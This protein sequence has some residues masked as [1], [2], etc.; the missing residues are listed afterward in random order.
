[1]TVV[2]EP[3]IVFETVPRILDGVGVSVIITLYNYDSYITDALDS[4]YSQSYQNIELI[5]VDDASKDKS[6]DVARKWLEENG[7]RFSQARLLS[8]I[9]N[10]GLAQARNTAFAHARNEFIFVLDADNEIYPDAIVKLL[11]VCTSARAEA[12]YSQLENFGAASGY[13]RSGFWN[14]AYLALGN[15]ID[16]MALI[17]KSAWLAVG[18]Y[19][20]FTISGWEDYDLWCKFVEHGFKGVFVPELLC[21]YRVHGSSMLNQATNRNLELLRAEMV[22]R[23]P[24]LRLPSSSERARP[25]PQR[26]ANKQNERSAYAFTNIA[27]GNT[28]RKFHYRSAT[29]DVKIIKQIFLEK[30]YDLRTLRNFRELALFAQ[31]QES[32]GLRPLIIDAGANIGAS[33][34]YFSV[35]FPNGQVIAIEPEQE[36]FELLAKNVSGLN[37]IPVHGAVASSAGLATVSDPGIGPWGYRTKPT[38]AADQ[39]SEVVQQI[40]INQ[41]Y[42]SFQPACFPFIVKID[43]EGGEKDLF[44]ANTEWVD[45]TPFIVIEL[46]DRFFSESEKISEPFLRCV[47]QLDRDFFSAGELSFSIAKDLNLLGSQLG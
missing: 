35:G 39:S 23:H 26:A 29:T 8:H 4:V 2:V 11:S 37:V 28:S 30:N 40:T 43:I 25:D 17:K 18:G 41:I 9:E 34:L 36:N 21:R 16:A 19:S 7:A 10:C 15:Y 22:K 31:N 44:S 32:K 24:W 38:N 13:G 3:K 42:E 14:P 47:S 27:I 46:H 1:M 5:V 33:A 45:R 20:Y 6:Q 12:A